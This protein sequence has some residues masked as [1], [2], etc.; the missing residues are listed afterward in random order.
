MVE[1][2][3][4]RNKLDT[5]FR[6]WGRE[7]AMDGVNIPQAKDESERGTVGRRFYLGMS[8]AMAIIEAFLSA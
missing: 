5:G 1:E 7:R 2:S 3:C 6:R 8:L 4:A